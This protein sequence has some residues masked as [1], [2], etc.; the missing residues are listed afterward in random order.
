MAHSQ[1]I[2]TQIK[3][4]L[5]TDQK[6]IDFYAD[7]DNYFFLSEEGETYQIESKPNSVVEVL[8][9]DKRGF[10]QSKTKASLSPIDQNKFMYP[11][12]NDGRYYLC[13]LD[14]YS[15]RVIS[16]DAKTGEEGFVFF[17]KGAPSGLCVADNK[18]WYLSNLSKAR[19]NSIL[20]CYDLES[21]AL[22]Q[23]TT[24]PVLDAK[25]LILGEDGTFWCFENSS[26]SIIGITLNGGN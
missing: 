16:C 2:T 20:R 14:G 18:I 22:L 13:I 19:S 21:R 1:S 25:G 23:T 10:Y 9:W 8:G 5:P 4:N 7:G 24:I 12:L 11:C 6:I 26:R 17:L 15:S 3:T